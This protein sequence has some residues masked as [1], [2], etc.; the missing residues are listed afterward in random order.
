MTEGVHVMAKHRYKMMGLLL[1]SIYWLVD[2][3]LHVLFYGEEHFE[4]IPSELNELWMRTAIF[5]LVIFLGGYADYQTKKILQK[6]KEKAKVFYAT[7]HATHHILHNFLNKMQLFQVEAE[8]SVD[9][10]KELLALF[11]QVIAGTVDQLEK[12]ESISS[13]SE[14]KIKESLFPK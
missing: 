3:S 2:S 8:K 10:D 6:E 11:A 12:L 14:E 5:I 1:A 13:I 4:F 9:F 7:I